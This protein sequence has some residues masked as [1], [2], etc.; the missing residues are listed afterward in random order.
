MEADKENEMKKEEE[1]EREIYKGLC[2]RVSFSSL[3]PS[4]S[5]AS[6]IAFDPALI[7]NA[8]AIGWWRRATDSLRLRRGNVLSDVNRHA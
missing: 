2:L 5:T 8:F 1:R 4:F 6:L 7:P 3:S